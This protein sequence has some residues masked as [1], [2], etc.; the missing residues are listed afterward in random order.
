V[1]TVGQQRMDIG[2]TPVLEPTGERMVPE[3]A[4]MSTFWEHVYRYAF[5]CRY[6]S[7][8]RVLDIACGEGY[9]SAALQ[10]TG[11]A[12]VIGVD[13]SESACAHAHKKY[14]LDARPGSAEQIPLPDSSVE[15]VVSFETIEHVSDP[16][17]FLHECVRVLTPGGMLVISTP[18][19]EVYSG[20]LGSRNQYHCSEMTRE[21]FT[22]VL[23]ARFHDAHF[24]TQRPDSVAWWSPRTLVCDST[25]WRHIR[26]FQRLRRA[27]QRRIFFEAISEPT[28]EQRASA[29]DIIL[30]AARSRRRLLNQYV[31]R[32][33]QRWH[34]EESVYIIATAIR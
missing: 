10:K 26:G 2:N 23:L 13:A 31:V 32:P 5:A 34:R 7:G 16:G 17:A 8:K 20:R 25:P 19:K 21:Q 1:N 9:G 29:V 33:E 12:K 27:I 28:E 4:H 6:V 3:S 15:V 18:N 24:Y 30:E 22:S 14:G 11:A